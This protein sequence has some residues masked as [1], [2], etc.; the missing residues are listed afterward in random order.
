VNIVILGGTK[1][2]G[3]ALGRL[4][5]EHGDRVF[6]LGRSEVD[7]QRSAVDL[8]L[9]AGLGSVPDVAP[10]SHFARCDLEQPE[11][12]TAALDAAQA[13]FAGAAIDA[14]VVTAGLFATQDELESDPARTERLLR[15][16][17]TNTVL[18]C[19]EA[20]KRLLAQGGG[21]L[22]VFS[23]VAGD[24]ARKPVVLYG[25]SKAGLSAYLDGIDHKF[26]GQGL[27]VLCVRPGFVKTGMTAGLK[28]PPFAGE[29]TQV[30][31]DV[32]RALC[33]RDP[34]TVLYTP[35]IWQLVMGTI[36]TLPRAVMRRINF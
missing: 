31:R 21:T 25:A 24:R 11:G 29:P 2:M 28:P 3:R 8:D 34:R 17:F 26:H 12:F 30:A 35:W 19:E 22:C 18:F 20:R 15:V 10:R 9:R 23:S 4:C 6:L 27:R 14:I 13:H 16:N 36:A 33:G 32:R 5:V 7:L 1:G